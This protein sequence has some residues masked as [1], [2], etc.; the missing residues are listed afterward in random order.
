M[1]QKLTT[2]GSLRRD[3]KVWTGTFPQSGACTLR[4]DAKRNTTFVLYEF[5]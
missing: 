5:D 4:V 2:N 1:T 3:A